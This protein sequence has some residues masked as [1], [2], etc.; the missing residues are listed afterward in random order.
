[1]STAA[2]PQPGPKPELLAPA[3]DW[4]CLRAAAGN[5]E[6]AFYFGLTNFDAGPRSCGSAGEAGPA[7]FRRPPLDR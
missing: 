5:R 6:D 7:Q 3:G 2:I 1:M 4:D